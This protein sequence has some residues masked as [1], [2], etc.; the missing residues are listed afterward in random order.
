MWTLFELQGRGLGKA[1]VTL[2]TTIVCV[3]GL[4][5]VSREIPSLV[6]FTWTEPQ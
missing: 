2:H 5:K 1:M 6:Q 4:S 3:W